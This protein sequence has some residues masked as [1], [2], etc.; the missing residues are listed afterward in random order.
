MF[1][2]LGRYILENGAWRGGAFRKLSAGL[3]FLRADFGGSPPPDLEA[4]VLVFLK[5]CLCISVSLFSCQLF[6]VSC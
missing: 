4:L 3:R 6:A 5:L 1:L 2:A